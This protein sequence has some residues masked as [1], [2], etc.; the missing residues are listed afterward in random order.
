MNKKILILVISFICCSSSLKKSNDC[1]KYDVVIYKFLYNNDYP[2]PQTES[3]FWLNGLNESE[4]AI[5]NCKQFSEKQLL[6]FI[7]LQKSEQ[8]KENSD[9]FWYDYAF[10]FPTKDTIYSNI[11][12][13]HWKIKRKGKT[14]YYSGPNKNTYNKK[15]GL[16]S[17]FTHNA[18]FHK[19]VATKFP[20]EE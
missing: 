13:D 6:E 14:E 16:L 17:F 8:F 4:F 15:M 2:I 20:I 10:V 7:Y 9:I 18:F 19:T 1:N 12:L 5:Y 3:S 11:R